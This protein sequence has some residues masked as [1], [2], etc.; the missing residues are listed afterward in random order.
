MFQLVPTNVILP[1]KDN[2]ETQVTSGANQ[3]AQ[4]CIERGFSPMVSKWH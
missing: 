1:I 2:F 4:I 3:Q